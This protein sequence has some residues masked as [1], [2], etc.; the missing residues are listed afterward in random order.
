MVVGDPRSPSMSSPTRPPN[1]S[2]SGVFDLGV[3]AQG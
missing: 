1:E 2:N 3:A